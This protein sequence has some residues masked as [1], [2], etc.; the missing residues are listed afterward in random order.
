MLS[1]SVEWFLVALLYA[2]LAYDL[3][4]YA[5]QQSTRPKSNADKNQRVLHQR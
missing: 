1:L 4:D 5:F 2:S 3:I